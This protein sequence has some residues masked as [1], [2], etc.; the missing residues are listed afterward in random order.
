MKRKSI[1]ITAVLVTG[2]SAFGFV[3]GCGNL[4][5]VLGALGLTPNSVTLRVINETAFD[6]EPN[7][8]VSVFEGLIIDAVTEELLKL[9]VNDQGFGPLEPGSS[10]S[11]TYDCDDI[12]AVMAADAELKTG[13]GFSPEDDTDVFVMDDDFDC[14]DI[15]VIRF[16]GSA[17]SFTAGISAAA[18][19]PISLLNALSNR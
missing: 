10:V 11:R 17:N 1:V 15:V 5:G 9:D 8:Y 3:I 14:G 13:L 18:I 16:T 7:V 19:D 6:V 12:G 4:S 2:G